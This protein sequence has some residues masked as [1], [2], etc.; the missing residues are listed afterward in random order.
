MGD[1]DRP[2]QDEEELHRGLP[3]WGEGHQASD[4]LA[5]YDRGEHG[6]FG[7]TLRLT[8][9]GD[10]EIW[11]NVGVALAECEDLDATEIDVRVEHGVVYLEGSVQR[12]YEQRLARSLA[13]DV[14]GVRDVRDML[15]HR[16]PI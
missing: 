7:R 5:E 8:S 15:V 6:S 9:H 4:P 12:P 16:D 14:P 2:A 13:E 3:G 1:Q 11:E 10:E